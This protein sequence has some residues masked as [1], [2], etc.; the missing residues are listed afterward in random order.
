MTVQEALNLYPE[1]RDWLIGVGG[2]YPKL[3]EACREIL[4]QI[5]GITTTSDL[6]L[7]RV[8][9]YD[10]ARNMLAEAYWQLIR[11]GRT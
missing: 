2:P 1:A 4:R 10:R 6:T 8:Q 7:A 5:E 11:G 3:D 9:I